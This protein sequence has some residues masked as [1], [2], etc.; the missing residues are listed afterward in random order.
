MVYLIQVA[1]YP[2]LTDLQGDI[3]HSRFLFG[4]VT[5]NAESRQLVISRY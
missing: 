1:L 4:G 5:F 3:Q 2:A